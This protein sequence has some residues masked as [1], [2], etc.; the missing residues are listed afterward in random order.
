MRKLGW[1][2]VLELND[3]MFECYTKLFYANLNAQRN[4]D[5]LK[6]YL[7]GREVEI[8]TSLLNHILGVPNEEELVKPR[9]GEFGIEEYNSS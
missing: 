6:V 9:K 8:T 1:D 3:L 7:K 5:P 2:L 4:D